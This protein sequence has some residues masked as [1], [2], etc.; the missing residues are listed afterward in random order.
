MSSGSTYIG[1]HAISTRQSR[2]T[3]SVTPARKVLSII[4]GYR[5]HSDLDCIRHGASR[6]QA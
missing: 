4:G 3:D 6:P 1:I 5:K 2:P